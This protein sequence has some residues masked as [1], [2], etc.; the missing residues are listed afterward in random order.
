MAAFLQR[1][2]DF[3]T[4]H[5]SKGIPTSVRPSLFVCSLCSFSNFE[6]AVKN[7]NMP[8]HK[9]VKQLLSVSINQS[10]TS[11]VSHSMS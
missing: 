11:F 10:I 3:I 9:E 7:A 2:L 5:V 8:V 1:L 4:H 6:T